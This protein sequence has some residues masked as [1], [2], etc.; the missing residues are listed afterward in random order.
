MFCTFVAVV[1]SFFQR[2]ISEVLQPIATKLSYVVGSD[3]N[4][5]NLGLSS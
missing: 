1:Y 4:L 3:V 5:R 2:V